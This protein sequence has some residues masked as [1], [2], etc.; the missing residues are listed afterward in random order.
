MKILLAFLLIMASRASAF[1]QTIPLPNPSFEKGDAAPAG[2]TLSGGKGEWLAGGAPDGNRAVAV[3]GTGSDSNF[4]RSGALPMKPGAVYQLRFKARRD[5]V[6]GGTPVTGPSFCNRDLGKIPAE[7]ADYE[8]V[9]VT[10]RNLTPGQ[11]W[12]KF[13]QWQV[14]GSVAFDSQDLVRAMPVYARKGDLAL[15]EGEVVSGR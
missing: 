1:A 14:T 2:W 11:S 8:S 6:G 5:G 3:T 15:G 4:W 12:I 13:G 9:F 7:W 10:P